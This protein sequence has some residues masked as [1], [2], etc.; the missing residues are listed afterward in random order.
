MSSCE[1]TRYTI[2]LINLCTMIEILMG[3]VVVVAAIVA[4]I[5]ILK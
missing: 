5:S 1:R 2:N 3:C 4:N